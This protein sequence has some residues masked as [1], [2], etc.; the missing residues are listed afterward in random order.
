MYLH[1]SSLFYIYKRYFGLE[2]CRKRLPQKVFMLESGFVLTEGWCF[3]GYGTGFLVFGIP[4]PLSP[5]LWG[6]F[7]HGTCRRLLLPK[8]CAE[9]TRV[10]WGG[11]HLPQSNCHLHEI[12]SCLIIAFGS[13]LE[14]ENILPVQATGACICCK[15]LLMQVGKLQL[16]ELIVLH[17][18]GAL[19]WY[20]WP[21]SFPL[22]DTVSFYFGMLPEATRLSK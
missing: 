4:S 6:F 8:L 5:R 11:H 14:Q 18:S 10:A 13:S 22:Y 3:M 20:L 12:C 17:F 21:S 16:V 9:I 1:Y 2:V 15:P 19:L 7:Q